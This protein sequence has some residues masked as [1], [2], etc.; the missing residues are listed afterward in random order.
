MLKHK[1]VSEYRIFRKEVTWV[2]YAL[3]WVIRFVLLYA[4]VNAIKEARGE[5]TILQLGV[6]FALSFI[7]PLLHLLP[8]SVF[9]ARINF[10]VQDAVVVMLLTTAYF[11][12]YKGFYSNVE[13]YDAY[14]H[15]IGCF[16][17]V[18]AGYELTMALKHDK[19]T[20]APVVAA[21]CGFGLSFFFAVGWEIFEFFCDNYFPGSNSQNWANGNSN[22]LLALLPP[23]DPQR[24]ALLDT[25][26]D[27]IAGT[28]GSLLGGIA[29][30]PY[31]YLMNKKASKLTLMKRKINKNNNKNEQEQQQ[32][33]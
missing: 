25:M 21:M 12:Q 29:L 2:E 1:L 27:M 24:Y 19:L 3:W 7:L 13:W 20:L 23:I 9:L 30:F 15:I 4:L 17:F 33:G 28:I 5:V 14:L 11:G 31:V 10:R 6:E 32:V 16:V 8:R 26:S 18:Y 22:Q